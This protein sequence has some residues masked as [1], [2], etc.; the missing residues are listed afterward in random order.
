M[1]TC[2]VFCCHQVNR[3]IT[4][5]RICG[6]QLGV[7]GASYICEMLMENDCITHLVR[8]LIFVDDGFST[9]ENVISVGCDL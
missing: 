4:S 3:R 5:L 1:L 6:N 2:L 7:E 8:S 9:S